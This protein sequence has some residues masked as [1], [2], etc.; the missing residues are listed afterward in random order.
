MLTRASV[1]IKDQNVI[2]HFFILICNFCL[3]PNQSSEA[4][5]FP[6]AHPVASR[7]GHAAAP[8]CQGRPDAV[9][10]P[11]GCAIPAP[12]PSSSADAIKTFQGLTAKR[13]RRLDRWVIQ[14]APFSF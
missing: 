9:L 1:M 4:S 10:G 6:D 5:S 14:E 13:Q 8:S 7:G 3:A 2:G 12:S 11:E